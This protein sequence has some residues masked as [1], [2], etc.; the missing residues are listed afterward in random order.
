MSDLILEDGEV[1]E[2]DLGLDVKTVEEW[3]NS[4]SQSR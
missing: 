2:D 1:F 4:V 3:L